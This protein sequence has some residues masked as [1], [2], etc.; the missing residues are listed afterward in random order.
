MLPKL[1]WARPRR[2]GRSNQERLTVCERH[3]EVTEGE[4]SWSYRCAFE[5]PFDLEI[6]VRGVGDGYAVVRMWGKSVYLKERR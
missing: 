6:D 4:A 3:C 5:A 2:K 1:Y